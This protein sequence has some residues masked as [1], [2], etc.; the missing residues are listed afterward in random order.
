MLVCPA[1]DQLERFFV[2]EATA[3]ELAR[4]QRHLESCPRCRS[5][6]DEARE[7][8][9][10]LVDLRRV[11]TGPPQQ[12]SSSAAAGLGCDA[13]KPDVC[14]IPGY[15]V[16]RTLG[17]GGMG[18]VYEALQLR[19]QRRVALKLVRGRNV[20][21]RHR[22]LFDRE[23]QALA[24]LQHPCIASL[25][26]AG[27]TAV[28]E[29]YFVMERIAGRPLAAFA[30]DQAAPRKKLELMRRVCDA[31]HYAHQ[32]GVIH[33]DLKPSNILIDESGTPKVLDFGLARLHDEDGSSATLLTDA[34]KIQ[35]T[36]A[37][38]SPEQ[39]R[40]RPEL[41]DVRSDV[42]SLGVLFYE[43]MTGELPYP[44]SRERIADSIRV[45]CEQAPRRPGAVSAALRGDLETI[46]L[47]ALEKEPDRRYSSAAAL[48]DDIERYLARQPIL[49]RRPSAAYQI[50][51]LVER[52]RLPS[53]LAATLVLAVVGFGAAMAYLYRTADALRG[54]AEKQQVAAE[55]ARDAESAS[56]RR[57]EDAERAAAAEAAT[58]KEVESFLR[59]L[60]A[61]SNP[62]IARE[63]DTGLLMD[64]LADADRRIEI[65]LRDQ[66][67]AAA[68]LHLTIGETYASLAA[69]D[70]A[71]KHL[72]LALTLS[73]GIFGRRSA[74][75]A[76]VLNAIGVL[77]RQQD[78]GP[79][80][81]TFHRE[82]LSIRR[83]VL[84]EKHKLVAES[85]NNLATA[86]LT[87][88]QFA[89]AETLLR[90]AL[91][92]RLET[93][94]Q[95]DGHFATGLLNLGF[96]LLALQR[97]EEADA[98]LNEGIRLR[99]QTAGDHDVMV[100]NGLVKL[101]VTRLHLGR[102]EEAEKAVREALEIRRRVLPATH[103]L[104]G[105]TLSN[106]AAILDARGKTE[107][108]EASSE[109]A[110]PYLRNPAAGERRSLPRVLNRLA[111]YAQQRDDWDAALRLREED[112]AVRRE[113]YGDDSDEVVVARS[114]AAAALLR[115]NRAPEAF[116]LL[117][118]VYP[119]IDRL[120]SRT[121]PN[122]VVVRGNY[123]RALFEIG[124]N[125]E[126]EAAFLDALATA[127]SLARGPEAD[128]LTARVREL[129]ADFYTRT[130]RP[131]LAEQFRDPK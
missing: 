52:H 68:R 86:L 36:L 131:E 45:I 65:E 102:A 55:A 16:E 17:E 121:N 74:E 28:G 95:L 88:S 101:G 87:Q 118:D 111:T 110:L 39:T 34:G 59:T 94:E 128:G 53:A 97:H 92:A 50:R 24:R 40:G 93:G 11:E 79:E 32:R 104:I 124:R 108:A 75:V 116:E 19:T 76:E 107:E 114:N 82:A 77:R 62:E 70:Q 115:L 125:D 49:A 67:K 4:I 69:Y 119:S 22:R 58:A 129:I 112:L 96:L 84:G 10:V 47:K 98:V 8:E 89:E 41:I 103:P 120:L 66:P 12:G 35:G 21:A 117:R 60:L 51:K 127:D 43:L 130:N 30:T 109:E 1:D 57:A 31:I 91:D 3:E 38:M 56:R 6:I 64:L 81:A 26:E 99:R 25:F 72:S 9:A 2:G 42:Y 122:R 54:D 83:D 27:T 78:R 7:D 113:L 33:R 105:E 48:G 37:Y 5:W 123:A 44:V 23:V 20:D 18:V 80:A 61:S 14:D 13:I 85:L 126:A 29:P 15:T 90:Q 100:A 106:L 73:Q 46:L 63:R 71:D